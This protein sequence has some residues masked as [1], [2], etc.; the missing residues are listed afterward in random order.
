MEKLLKGAPIA[1]RI[2]ETA[3]AQVAT[4]PTV[5]TLAVIQVGDDEAA[6]VYTGSMKKLMAGLDI[7]LLDYPLPDTILTSELLALIETLNQSPDI[8]GIFVHMPLPSG[9][10]SHQI[11]EAIDPKKDIDCIT[12]H[13]MGLVATGNGR[14]F[15]CTPAAVLEVLQSYN[16]NISG[17]HVV[18]IGRSNIVGKP[19]ATMLTDQ[20]ATVTLCHSRTKDLSIH[21]QQ[22]DILIVAVGRANF[23]TADMVKPG[24]VV[25]DVGINLTDEGHLVGDASFE[26]VEP[27]AGSITPVP[28]GVGSVTVAM[29]ARNLLHL[30]ELQQP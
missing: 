29:L 21:T 5:P 28:G 1:K 22:A 7:Q 10:D 14:I 15:P 11:V 17:K 20:H 26:A 19:V 12:M 23:L 3:K 6:K 4:L 16:I 2:K 9:F 27:V 13:N 30:Y 8:T 24:T 25:I 18:V